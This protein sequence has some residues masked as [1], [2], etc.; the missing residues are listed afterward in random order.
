[1]YVPNM[2]ALFTNITLAAMACH[3]IPLT[4]FVV[5]VLI[6]CC[7]CPLEFCSSGNT[8]AEGKTASNFDF[9][10]NSNMDSN[11]IDSFDPNEYPNI[12]LTSNRNLFIQQR[13]RMNEGKQVNW[14]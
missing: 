6:I 5:V 3:S 9:D 13:Q 4:S 11:R 12:Y 10:L 14:Q 2:F 7:C 8:E 1:M